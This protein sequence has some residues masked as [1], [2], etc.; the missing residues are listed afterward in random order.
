[1]N[2]TDRTSP[3]NHTQEE[4]VSNHAAQP[5]ASRGRRTA[6]IATVVV[7]FLAIVLVGQLAMKT[8]TS[9]SGNSTAESGTSAS[10]ASGGS[11]SAGS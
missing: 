1:M 5:S 9:P 3:T 6:V 4:T 11:Q 10:A 8:P 2:P 7:V